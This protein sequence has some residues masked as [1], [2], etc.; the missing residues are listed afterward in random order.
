MLALGLAGFGAGGFNCRVDDLGMSRCGNFLHAGESLAADRALRTS[1]MT[2]LGAGSGLFSNLNG[3]M[4]GSIDCFGFGLV[5]DRAGVGL[6]TGIFTGRSGRDLAL[7]PIVTL[8]GNLFLRFDNRSADRAAD[9]IRQTRFGT[10]CG[11]AHNDLLSVAG[12]RDLSLRNDDCVADGAVFT[13]GQASLRAGRSLCCIDYFCVAGRRDFFHTGENRITNGALRTGFM[14]SLGAGSGLLGNF[15][16]SMTGSF[17]FSCLGCIAAL[18]LASALF[19]A[20]FRAGRGSRYSPF[21]PVV[22]ERLDFS[23]LGRIAAITLASALFFALFRAG[24]R[25]RYSPFAPIMTERFDFSCLGCIAALT[26]ASVL[27]FALFRAG[28]GSRYSPFAPVVTE[29]LDF[30]RLGRIAAITLAS[31]LFFALFRAGRRS[32]Y[33]PF[34]PVMTELPNYLRL[35]FVTNLT[36]KFPDTGNCT[37]WLNLHHA[38]VPAV[39]QGGNVHVAANLLPARSADGFSCATGLG[40]GGR[41]RTG[42]YRNNLVFMPYAIVDGFIV[43]DSCPNCNALRLRLGVGTVGVV[44]FGG[45]NGDLMC[46]HAARLRVLIRLGLLAGLALLVV[47]AGT[48][49]GADV[50]AAC[51]GVDTADG[52][53]RTVDVHL[54]IRQRRTLT[55]P[56]GGNDHRHVLCIVRA[57]VAAPLIH[58]VDVDALAAGHHQLG[59]LSDAGLYAGQQRCRLVDGQLAAGGQIDGHVVGQRQNIAA[60]A[61]THACQL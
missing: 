15:N 6:D 2:S 5:A 17:D 48:L 29:R 47:D 58:V 60:G 9:A 22:T 38:F 46:R 49:A 45:S 16:G 30:S 34:A 12:R 52:G 40:T 4:T 32:R 35:G 43:F 27:F 10:G 11:L 53:Q 7:I 1:F 33:S 44:Q 3:S 56:S 21:A 37:G 18:T 8:G 51:G 23:R 57:A 59:A 55:C 61:D 24:R 54:Y 26:V 25:S 36:S 20:L 39:S 50:R 28:R 19:F 13:L 31:A 41:L 14:T 42:G